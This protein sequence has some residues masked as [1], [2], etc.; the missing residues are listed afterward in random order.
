MARRI[1]AGHYKFGEAEEVREV[2]HGERRLCTVEY[3]VVKGN[4]ANEA[5]TE[6]ESDERAYWSHFCPDALYRSKWFVYR[7]E[8]DPGDN[9]GAR[10]Q[11][12]ERLDDKQA[13]ISWLKSRYAD[14]FTRTY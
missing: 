6:A 12:L 2:R 3:G 14:E 10:P 4:T 1:R 9:P 7:V 5:S 11:L 8:V 13:A